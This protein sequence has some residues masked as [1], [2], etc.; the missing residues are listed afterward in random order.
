MAAARTPGTIFLLT[1]SAVPQYA[2]SPLATELLT[3]VGVLRE[4]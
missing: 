1:S 4:M 2:L 3:D